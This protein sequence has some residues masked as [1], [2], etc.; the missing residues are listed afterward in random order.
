[1]KKEISIRKLINLLTT[2]EGI[3]TEIKDTL[4]KDNEEQEYKVGDIIKIGLLNIPHLIVYN[5]G[6]KIINLTSGA[7]DNYLHPVTINIIRTMFHTNNIE[8]T[9]NINE[10][11]QL[12]VKQK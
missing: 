10:N 8:Y 6:W 4:T 7:S 3:T 5:R 11:I 12:I 2:L 9:G 1:M